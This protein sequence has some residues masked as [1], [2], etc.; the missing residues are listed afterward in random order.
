MRP[1][2]LRLRYEPPERSAAAGKGVADSAFLA[3]GSGVIE[4]AFELGSPAPLANHHCDYHNA[5]IGPDG[6][7]KM[8][9]VRSWPPWLG[10]TAAVARG[11]SAA[12]M[13][14]GGREEGGGG[15]G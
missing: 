10:C 7:L 4:D 6:C 14:A 5:H 1:G 15:G 13:V 8:T 9:C 12:G 3:E 2:A 11:H